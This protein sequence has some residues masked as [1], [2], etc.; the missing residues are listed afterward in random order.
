MHGRSKS[1]QLTLVTVLL[2]VIAVGCAKPTT[3]AI[4]TSP[5][6]AL[7][8]EVALRSD[9]GEQAI[10]QF[11][12][13][14][15]GTDVV[16]WSRL[17]A[18]LADGSIL[19]G[20]SKITAITQRNLHEEYTQHP[21]KRSRVISNAEETTVRF[22]EVATPRREWEVILRA[23]D[24]GVAFRYRFLPAGNLSELA[25]SEERTEFTLP[26]QSLVHALTLRGF[27]SAYEDHYEVVPAEELQST[28]FIGLPLLYQL[29]DGQWAAIT[30]ADLTEYAG[31]YVVPSESNVRLLS[32][33]LAP[34]PQEPGVA[35][36]ASLP[37]V[38]PWRTIMIGD[39]AGRLVESDIVLNLSRPNAITDTS[40]IKPG[41]TTFPWWNG[42]PDEGLGFEPGLNFATMKHYIDFCAENGIPY[43]SLD[44]VRGLAWYGGRTRPYGGDDITT[45]RPEME[46]ERLIAYAN[47][48]G[49]RLRLWMHWE[50][51]EAQMEEAFPLYRQWG[52]EG[53]MLD[54]MNRDDQEMHRFLERAI[55][56]AAEN[57]LTVTLH[58][59]AKPTGLERMYP[60]LLNYEGVYNLE[61]NKF[62][63]AGCS[64]DHQVMVPFTRM[65]AGPLD[66]HQ[67]SFRAVPR[68][69]FVHRGIEP[70]V[71]GTPAR[72]LAMYVVYQNHL[73]MMCDYPSAYHEHPALQALVQIPDT[74]DDTR[75]VSGSVGHHIAIARRSGS[76]WHLG[77]MSGEAAHTFGVPLDFLGDGQYHA[78]LWMDDSTSE[79]GLKQE[80]RIVM[81]GDE[82]TLPCEP[83]GA[84]YGRF[85]RVE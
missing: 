73:P 20:P 35:V 63:A 37:H 41:K 19:G 84:A 83:G 60:N 6:G 44:G 48:R 71:I 29:P 21:G 31:M 32:T 10:P 75:V 27:D 14:S 51:A 13:T 40:W 45:A 7:A 17:G 15:S 65:L 54:F 34:L 4:N 66:F 47:E 57:H 24:D 50:G 72:N 12:V 49:V 56:L 8:I 22:R 76:E 16:E 69:Q 38:S 3:R 70:L 5:D 42:Y 64:P 11:R 59:S 55:K 25:L 82:L 46:L 80:E 85:V 33:R 62:V 67:G 26:S 23:Y 30:E 36:R 43:H 68:E 1:P 78:T 9:G 58:G 79:I 28:W 18:N 77:A 61:Y 53:I 74:W 2:L 81:A 39:S 52:I